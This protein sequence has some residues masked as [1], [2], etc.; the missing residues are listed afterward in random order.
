MDIFEFALEKEQLA[1]ET[2]KKLA[3]AAPSDSIRGI[4]NLL[5]HEE[6][7]HV[8]MVRALQQNQ[9][10]DIPATQLLGEA[11]KVFEK[12]STAGE[13]FDFN[14]SDTDLYKKAR[15]IELDARDYYKARAAQTDNEELTGILNR[16]AAE[17]QK[18]YV[19]VDNLC[20]FIERP[21]SYLE[22]AEF[23]HLD[24]YAE[25]PM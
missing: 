11:K 14:I 13:T 19:L 18:H 23:N 3:Q 21:Q 5:A 17:E 22:D 20:Q 15:Q 2:Y 4:L 12:I 9:S 16:L 8:D 7:K 6:L 10:V 25:E 24:N 1:H